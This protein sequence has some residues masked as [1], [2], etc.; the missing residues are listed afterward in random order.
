[1]IYV[2]DVGIGTYL[3]MVFI[4]LHK[5]CII[6]C[7]HDDKAVTYG[8]L[9]NILARFFKSLYTEWFFFFFF[10]FFFDLI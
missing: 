2:L 4:Q 3:S 10:F 6:V 9:L 5:L 1:M 7:E 8:Y